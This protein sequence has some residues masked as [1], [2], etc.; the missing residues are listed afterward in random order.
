MDIYSDGNFTTFRFETDSSPILKIKAVFTGLLSPYPAEITQS[1]Q[2]L[3]LLDS[4]HYFYSPYV[5]VH[6]K[7][8]Y[9]LASSSIESFTKLSPHSVR[10]SSIH[11]GPFQ[12]I[13][14][15]SVNLY[16]YRRFLLTCS[17][18]ITT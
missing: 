2:Q 10:G 16:F 8:I 7:S 3:V 5:T 4:L 9:K 14:A 18:D 12:N 1:D 6:Q 17:L 13:P 11:F 15:H